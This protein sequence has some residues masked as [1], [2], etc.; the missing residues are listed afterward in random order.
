MHAYDWMTT[1]WRLTLNLLTTRSR[2]FFARS[3][4]KKVGTWKRNLPQCLRRSVT[5]LYVS[6]LCLWLDKISCSWQRQVHVQIRS[7][8]L[9]WI[10]FDSINVFLLKRQ[11]KRYVVFIFLYFL[12]CRFRKICLKKVFLNTNFYFVYNIYISEKC[13]T[14]MGREYIRDLFPL[15]QLKH[16]FKWENIY[17]TLSV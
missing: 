3:P 10:C 6:T 11:W 16:S 12:V 8:T 2:S 4:L 7:K 14:Q 5:S 17:F 13:M 9:K 15:L 1:W